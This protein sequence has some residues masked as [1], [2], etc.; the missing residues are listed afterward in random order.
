MKK[1]I[2]IVGFVFF[3][4]L[5]SL[6]VVRTDQIKIFKENIQTY[7]KAID[8]LE[9]R[10]NH[11]KYKIDSLQ[12]SIVFYKDKISQKEREIVILRE[13]KNEK[14]DSIVNLS[15]DKSI[16]F[17]SDYLSKESSLAE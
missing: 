7:E 3:L 6:L 15:L 10:V 17:L 12:E 9:K 5:V 13:T 16:R 2:N 14:V 4:Y 8:S 1:L 11:F